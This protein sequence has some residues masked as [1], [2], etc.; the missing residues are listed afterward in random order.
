MLMMDTM[1]AERIRLIIDT[2]EAVRRAV[3]RTAAERGLSPSELVNE[4]LERELAPVIEE[5]DR[6]IAGE[7]SPKRKPGAKS[8]GG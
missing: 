2:N 3:R 8:A 5:M 7:K 4:I 1:S 6:L